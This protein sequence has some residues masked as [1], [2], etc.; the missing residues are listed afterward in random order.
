MTI[1]YKD[2]INSALLPIMASTS[3]TRL[4]SEQIVIKAADVVSWIS[5]AK[6]AQFLLLSRCSI[7]YFQISLKF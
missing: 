1:S 5:G 4:S 7:D 2:W 3:L 6:H